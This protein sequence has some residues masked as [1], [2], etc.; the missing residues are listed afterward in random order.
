MRRVRSLQ[1]E[2][3]ADLDSLCASF[4]AGYEEVAPVD[5]ERLAFGTP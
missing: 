2:R 3:Q 4:L 1:R 5:R